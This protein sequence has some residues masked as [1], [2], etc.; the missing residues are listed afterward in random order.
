[1]LH[2]GTLLVQA[3][4][5][6]LHAIADRT[7]RQYV[8]KAV[9]SKPAQVLNIGTVRPGTLKDFREALLAAWPGNPEPFP[10]SP[11]LTE[12]A[13]R[14]AAEKYR[15]WAWNCGRSPAF[16]V[17]TGG[18]LG[19]VPVEIRYEARQGV[20]TDCAFRASGKAWD[21]GKRLIG[22]KLEPENIEKCCRDVTDF[23]ELLADLVL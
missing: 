22:E 9:P 1:M 15:T 11:E 5:E 8:S 21:A 13:E 16:S 12:A 2:H 7:G 17:E 18:F 10:L 20:I 4:L 19:D 23:A 14:L 3:D 6:R